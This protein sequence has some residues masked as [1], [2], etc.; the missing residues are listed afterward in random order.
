MVDDVVHK[1]LE[2][3]EVKSK[4]GN[5][6]LSVEKEKILSVLDRDEQ[7]IKEIISSENAYEKYKND[8]KD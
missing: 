5:S 7:E 4:I 8:L 2:R 3:K 1:F 6:S